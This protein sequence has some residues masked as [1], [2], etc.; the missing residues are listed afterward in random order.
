M[1]NIYEVEIV[2]SINFFKKRFLL[3]DTEYESE[4]SIPLPKYILAFSKENAKDIIIYSKFWQY[5]FAK[6][7]MWECYRINNFEIEKKFVRVK[8]VENKNL[9][10]LVENMNKEDFLEWINSEKNNNA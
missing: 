7:K 9:R 4:I 5:N 10:H 3:I 6:Q 2:Y 8:K 1:K